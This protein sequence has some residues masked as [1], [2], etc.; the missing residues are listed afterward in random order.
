[1]IEY[2][3]ELEN[4]ESQYLSLID[5]S[6]FENNNIDINYLPLR[7]YQKYNNLFST[8]LDLDVLYI[9]A[10]DN[11]QPQVFLNDNLYSGFDF[12]YFYYSYINNEDDISAY[13]TIKGKNRMDFLVQLFKKKYKESDYLYQYISSILE[14]FFINRN[15]KIYWNKYSVKTYLS[16]TMIIAKYQNKLS[17]N[18]EKLIQQVLSEIEKFEFEI[19]IKPYNSVNFKLPN[20]WY[21][22]PYKHL[23]NSMGTDGHKDANLIYPFYYTILR[24]YQNPNPVPYLKSVQRLKQNEFIT[25]T[26]YKEH[27]NLKYDFPCIYPE[28][29]YNLDPL[30]K[31]IYRH[32]NKRSYNPKLV[33]LIIGIESAHAGIYD[34]FYRLRQYSNNYE[35]DLILLKS[36]DFN[37]MLVRCCGFHKVTSLPDKIITTSLINYE[38]EFIEY[39]KKGW[40]IDFLPPIIINE[41]K[42]TL[43]E[44]PEEFLTIKK[45]LKKHN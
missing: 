10:L 16:S 19:P 5:E 1:M 41:S 35:Q 13:L 12:D 43:E 44:Y 28:S 40:K 31:N 29:Y 39:I 17:K 45:I 9:K 7:F 14:M 27:L 33:N 42:G 20:C 22:T 8:L 15:K 26:E 32:T 34:F 18:V 4:R 3:E 30:S 11:N 36:L 2:F 6:S 37:D 25:S 38:D 21:I 24:D 23:Y